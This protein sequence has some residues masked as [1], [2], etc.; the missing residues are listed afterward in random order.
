MDVSFKFEDTFTSVSIRRLVVAGWTGR[1][2][3]AVQH[4]IDELAELGI[5][6]PSQ[7]PLYYRVS[8]TL[9][10]Q[11]DSIEV[12]GQGSSGEV[13]P[14]LLRSG[15]RTYLGLASDHTDRDLEAHSVAASK[16]ACAKPV[17]DTLWDFDDVK[18]RLDDLTLKCWILENGHEVLYQ[19]GGLSA[20]RPLA[21]LCEGGGF[22]EGTAMLCG[23][24]PAIGGV[25]SAE[26][27]RMEMA[28]PTNGKTLSLSYSVLALPIV[29]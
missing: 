21:E 14:L 23:T 17:A 24:L 9:L 27:Y 19:T 25:R 6:P 15:G 16:Q 22:E 10:T 13:E 5:S 29:S 28:D 26:T 3:S 2:M 8:N 1:N 11:R 20:I 7:I 4:H 18:D 12:L